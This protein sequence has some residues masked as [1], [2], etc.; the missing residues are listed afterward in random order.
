MDFYSENR[1]PVLLCT[2]SG[3][4]RKILACK[5]VNGQVN[6]YES[7]PNNK[8]GFTSKRIGDDLFTI[9]QYGVISRFM[10]GGGIRSLR[11]SSQTIYGPKVVTSHSPSPITRT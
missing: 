5:L 3:N 11:G 2:D 1:D 7:V 8:M 9:D 6:G 4:V 10:L